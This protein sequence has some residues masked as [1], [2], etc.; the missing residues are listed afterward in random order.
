MQGTKDERETELILNF[1]PPKQQIENN[2]C[3]GVDW[4]TQPEIEQCMVRT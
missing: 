4:L 3:I 1:Y 2:D